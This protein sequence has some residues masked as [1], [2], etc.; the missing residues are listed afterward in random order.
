MP[1]AKPDHRQQHE[2]VM[3]RKERQ[4]ADSL[5][6]TTGIKNV[7]EGIGAVAKPVLDNLAIIMAAI[8][9]AEGMTWLEEQVEAANRKYEREKNENATMLYQQYVTSFTTRQ[10]ELKNMQGPLTAEQMEFINQEPM[11]L[12]EY[13]E[14]KLGG[15]WSWDFEDLSFTPTTEAG[16]RRATWWQENVGQPLRDGASKIVAPLNPANW[17]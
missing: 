6:I 13:Q 9:A 11:T 10:N 14:A 3:G 7:G 15:S 17:F 12:E 16:H 8:I 5:V 4:Y 1:K 2:F